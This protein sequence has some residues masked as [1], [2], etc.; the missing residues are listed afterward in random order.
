VGLSVVQGAR[1]ALAEPIIAVDVD[2]SKLA[3]AQGVGATHTVSAREGSPSTAIRALLSGAGVDHAF[4]AAGLAETTLEAVRACDA[5]GT[6]TILGSPSRG[7]SIDLLLEDLYFPRLTVRV[8]QYGDALA[9]R[10]LPW[11]SRQ[12]VSGGLNLGA[13]VTKVTEIQDAPFEVAAVGRSGIRTVVR[14]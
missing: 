8:S 6:C 1:L 7:S 9:S 11:L 5:G 10:D 3:I 4:E 13:M 2:D 14:F 12:A